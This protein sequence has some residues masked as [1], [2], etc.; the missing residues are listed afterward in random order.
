MKISTTIYFT[1]FMVISTLNLSK[2]YSIPQK[3][4]EDQFILTGQFTNEVQDGTIKLYIWTD[5]VSANNKYR[6]AHKVFSAKLKNGR[7]AFQIDSIKTNSYLLLSKEDLNG[8]PV[9]ILNMY[10]I[11]EGDQIHLN[12]YHEGKLAF[13]TPSDSGQPIY[14]YH[15][16]IS[17]KGSPK[18]QCRYSMDSLKQVYT[19]NFHQLP[20]NQQA[21]NAT[22]K[23][24]IT[25]NEINTEDYITTNQLNYLET[26]RLKIPQQIFDLMKVDLIS[27]NMIHELKYVKTT[28]NQSYTKV[29]RDHVGKHFKNSKLTKLFNGI[30]NERGINSIAFTMSILE[31]LQKESVFF[32][33]NKPVHELIAEKF[34]GKLKEKLITAYLIQNYAAIPNTEAKKI[35]AKAN[36]IIETPIYLKMLDGLTY[37]NVGTLL[38]PFELPDKDNKII[39]LS[40][41]RGKVLFIDFYYTGCSNCIGY[42]KRTVS[43]VKEYFKNTSDVSFVTISIDGNKQQWLKSLKSK[44]YTSE[45]AINLYTN[46]IGGNHPLIKQ[47]KITA[48][49]HAT[50]IDREGKIYNNTFVEL[51]KNHPNDLISSIKKALDSN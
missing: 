46:G 1:I 19:D 13:S 36:E 28:T 22:T 34:N 10:R 14:K 33:K 20:G 32:Y 45:N 16:Q 31:K 5:V 40:D 37:L 26:Y 29:D 44:L 21:K 4:T 3:K 42:N 9:P 35:L 39:K 18:Y 50:L 17:G 24:E 30:S 6:E 8:D 23:L 15:L 12:I 43:V 47:L 7:Y 49:P 41:F 48:Y 27:T 2:S 25:L 11:Q 51:G 38:Y